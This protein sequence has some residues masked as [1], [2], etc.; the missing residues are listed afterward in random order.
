MTSGHAMTQTVN[1]RPFTAEDGVRW[2]VS[3]CEICSDQNDSVTSFSQNTSTFHQRSTLIFIY[4][5][6]LPEAQRGEAWE[7]FKSNALR[8]S[9][10]VFQ[11]FKWRHLLVWGFKESRR[12]Q[13]NNIPLVF[14][15]TTL[16]LFQPH[17]D[18]FSAFDIWAIVTSF[19]CFLPLSDN[20]RAWLAIWQCYCLHN[21]GPVAQTV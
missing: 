8:K 15:P 20:R 21:M 10:G 1:R 12:E 2:Q 16:L 6:P 17:G 11:E 7:P 19:C 9:G 3:P 4:S 5:L 13:S 14:L 18:S